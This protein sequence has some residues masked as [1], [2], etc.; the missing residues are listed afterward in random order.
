M[1]SRSLMSCALSVPLAL[2]LAPLAFCAR[3]HS[4][5]SF[6]RLARAGMC[7]VSSVV[8]VSGTLTAARGGGS[9]RC[10]TFT[11][12]SFFGSLAAAAA[13][14]A[15]AAPASPFLRLAAAPPA[16]SLESS[17]SMRSS[18]S[19]GMCVD[20]TPVSPSAAATASALRILFV[21]SRSRATRVRASL[22]ARSLSSSSLSY[23]TSSSSLSAS[24]SVPLAARLSVRSCHFL[25]R[26][27]SSAI[28]ASC[29]PSM[30]LRRFCS[31]SHCFSRYALSAASLDFLVAIFSA[32][33]RACA[34][35]TAPRRR[36][37]TSA[38]LSA[39]SSRRSLP[40]GSAL[41]LRHLNCTPSSS[42][43]ATHSPSWI[44]PCRSHENRYGGAFTFR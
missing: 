11:R 30:V 10:V 36:S 35:S 42:M 25:M 17:S 21:N 33:M 4:R 28:S 22:L 9:S 7:S 40:H 29:R 1:G 38:L 20:P 19:S 32:T 23:S 16:F 31:I 8:N 5:I 3:F 44:S 27:R 37:V 43:V 13:A 41:V 34:C 39:V 12:T 2:M 24:G 26:S 15:P 18:S 14:S 6:S